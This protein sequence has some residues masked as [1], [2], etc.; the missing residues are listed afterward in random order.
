MA[1]SPSATG[2]SHLTSYFESVLGVTV[3]SVQGSQV[4]LQ[5]TGM[6]GIFGNG[7]KT[8]G[9]TLEHQVRLPPLEVRREPWDSFHEEVCKRTLLPE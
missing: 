1:F 5:C 4:C 6:S 9:V 2:L 7:D 3:E 8:L